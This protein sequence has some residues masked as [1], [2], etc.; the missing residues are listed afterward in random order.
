MAP[1]AMAFGVLE[2][3]GSATA[4]G[5]VIAS[6]SG[7]AA[8]LQLLGGALADRIS[9]QRMMVTADTLGM[10]SQGLIAFLLIT[11][12]ANVPV[13]AALMAVAATWFLFDTSFSIYGGNV[14]STMAGE[15]SF[16]I[17]LTLAMLGLGLLANGLRTGRFRVW[18]AVV[19]SLSAVSHGIVLIFVAVS[20]TILCLVWMDRRRLVYAVTTGVTVLLLSA[21]QAGG[22][23]MMK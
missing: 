11:G 7:A 16:S 14:K 23:F 2:L 9:R 8:L 21:G 17:S 12:Q 4:M 6:Q 15:Y 22:L 3:T 20:A 19:L 13:L 5:V 10:I 18:A 1:I